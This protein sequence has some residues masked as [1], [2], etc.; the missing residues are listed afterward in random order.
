MDDAN[1]ND[2]GGIPAHMQ[3]PEAFTAAVEEFAAHLGLD[4]QKLV[5]G[6][7]FECNGVGFSLNHFG[8]LDPHAATV[9]MDMGQVAK[10]SE[11]VVFRGL[12]ERNALSVASRDGYYGVLPESNTVVYCIRVPLDGD[13]RGA[14]AIALVV[15]SLADGINRLQELTK[16]L[17]EEISGQAKAQPAGA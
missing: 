5:Q 8:Q 12:L 3:P 10:G 14:D 15:G 13:A 6:H 17:L 9:F 16:K 11:A 1:Q 4:A 2:A 7:R